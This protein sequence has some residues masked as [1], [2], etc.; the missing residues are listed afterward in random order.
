MLRTNAIKHLNKAYAFKIFRPCMFSSCSG[1]FPLFNIIKGFSSLE[2]IP[3]KRRPSALFFKRIP[4]NGQRIPRESPANPPRIPRE[5]PACKSPPPGPFSSS[6]Q[7]YR[8]V[9]YIMLFYV[10]SFLHMNVFLAASVCLKN[11]HYLY[12][13]GAYAEVFVRRAP[14]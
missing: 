6:Q 9:F 14:W 1:H 10:A 12:N 7:T 4:P 11:G 8:A 5:S 13:S 2:R 3:L